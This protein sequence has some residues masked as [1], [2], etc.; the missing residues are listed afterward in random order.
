MTAILVILT[1]LAFIGV[2]AVVMALRRHHAAVP[3]AMQLTPMLEPRPP[4][5][6]FLDPRHAWVRITT[7]GTLRVGIDDFL[8]EALGEVEAVE[9]P[10]RGAQVKRG[11]PLLKL[12][13]RGRSLVVSAPTAGEVV[14]VNDHALAQ[15]WTV[16][17][18]PYGVGWVVALW[19]RDHHEAIKP[20][21]IGSAATA[22]LR[23]EMQRLADLLTPAGTL[24]TVPLLADGGV[25]RK[26]AL[27]SVDDSHWDAFQKEFLT[28][29]SLEA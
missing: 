14:A 22:F 1:I 18:D 8:S 20:L 6:I 27:A 12:K 11:D 17:R 13:V 5:G 2:D 15:P 28:P 3:M 29:S 25:P 24:A 10:P 21:R 4:Q 26:G 16:T 9:A 19:T 7:D 23:Q